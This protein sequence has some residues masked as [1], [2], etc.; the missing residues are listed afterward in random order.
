MSQKSGEVSPTT[1]GVN[2]CV[3]APL[4]TVKYFNLEASVSPLSTPEGLVS[5][6]EA[7]GQAVVAGVLSTESI[8]A[9]VARSV[10]DQGEEF[11]APAVASSSWEGAPQAAE[12]GR[13]EDGAMF[14]EQGGGEYRGVRLP[15]GVPVPSADMVRK[16][17]AAGHS[18]YRPW[19][20]CC[21][22]GAAN[23]PAHR[24]RAE[25]SI[26]D[27]PELHSDYGFFRDK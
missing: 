6:S 25:A 5:S 10:E 8:E 1:E 14:L 4:K 11:L 21:V 15:P 22:E 26:G 27:V 24:A 7:S 12:E 16:H 3:A 19:C 2:T 20:R 18:P 17:R 13:D 23:A 9:T